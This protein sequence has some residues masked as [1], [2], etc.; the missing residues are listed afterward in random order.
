M[1]DS[2]HPNQAY[3][4]IG[5]IHGHADELEA[6][7]IQLGYNE[8]S[9]H[10][11]HPNGRKVI[12]LGD[13]IDRG[14]KIRRTLQIVRGMIDAG[15]ASGILGNH[16]VNALRY[17]TSDGNGGYLRAHSGSKLKQHAATLS[18]IA[19]PSPDEWN[20]WLDWLSGLP[21]WLDLGPIRAV[22][23]SWNSKVKC[24]L[25]GIG[26]LSGETLKAYSI[27]D[28]ADYDA[29]STIINGPEARLPEPHSFK[30]PDG[31]ER[32]EIRTKWWE[33]L[34]GRSAKDIAYQGSVQN[35][36]D[37]LLESYPKITEIGEDAPITFFGHYAV[38]EDQPG[39]ILDNLAC[40]DYGMAKGGLLTAYRWDGE[41]K[42]DA[43]KFISIP[44]RKDDDE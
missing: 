32:F 42:L 23:A 21:L 44:Q 34:D 18:Q 16:E 5:D 17:H 30:T 2:N 39:P 13:Y 41:A 19:E 6:L 15:E 43:S 31:K 36:P 29:I 1:K 38:M 12:F 24:Q 22:H 28:T 37:V 7:L 35:I 10:F 9:G 14:P 33:P 25:K 11:S 20:D 4:I 40:L 27:K 3:D 26:K 8:G